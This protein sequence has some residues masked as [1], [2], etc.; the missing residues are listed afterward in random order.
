MLEVGCASNRTRGPRPRRSGAGPLLAARGG[1]GFTLIEVLVALAILVIGL[2]ATLTIFPR[3]FSAIEAGQQRT[4]AAQLAEGEIARWKLHPEALPDAIVATDYKGDLISA[5]LYNTHTSDNSNLE[6]LL[7]Y[8]ERVVFFPSNLDWVLLDADRVKRLFRPLVYDP[9]D[10]APTEFD[11][12]LAAGN[13]TPH[14]N[15]QP[16]TIYL[17]RTIIGERIDIRQLGTSELGVP[18]YLLSHAPLDVL[19][20][21]TDGNAYVDIYDARPWRYVPGRVA[22]DL[23]V[24]EFTATEAGTDLWLDFGPGDA[25]PAQPRAFKVDYT[26]YTGPGFARVLGLT[27]IVPANTTRASVSLSVSVDRETIQ[28]HERL[29]ALTDDQRDYLATRPQQWPRNAYYVAD[30]ET[31]VSGKIEFSPLLQ[32]DPRP[33]DITLVKVDYRVLDWQIL[34]FDVEVPPNG[35]VQLPVGQLKG[36]SYTNPPRQS[37][38]QE[39]ARG[40]KQYYNQLGTPS[41]LPASDPRTYAYLVAVDR[42]TGE[43]LVDHEGLTW[44]TNAWE[45]SKR[46]RVN[47]RDGLLYFNYALWQVER[48]DP[49]VDTPN[50]FGR[51]YRVFCRAQADWSVQLMI[52]ARQYPRSNDTLP[53]GAPAAGSAGTVLTYGWIPEEPR[54]IRFPL[55]DAGQAVAVDYYYWD[56][57]QARL[58][59]QQ[60]EVRNIGHPGVLLIGGEPYWVCKLEA[61]LA[62]QPNEW[63]PVVVRG[64]TL[65]ARS[66]WVTP[67]REATIQDLAAAFAEGR[68][69]RRSLEESWQHVIVTSYFSRTPI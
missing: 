6:R 13:V 68:A 64:L 67:G 56:E 23:D 4:V 39:V 1:R 30:P 46:F 27:I 43:I 17:P 36:A 40:V 53:G 5:T 49:Q 33:T 29:I 22:A 51:T 15:W 60:G 37:V 65:R 14:P 38:P 16:N 7:A 24:R 54:Q 20:R 12:A 28:V 41:Q 10:I 8:G 34:V 61:P 42:Q 19:R 21:E 2:Y 35:E 48:F 66:A 9:D 26:D 11:L 47:Y 45:R 50:R 32:S 44:P 18:F 62:E 52:A 3:G 59:Y 57:E 58:V 25:V 55:S 63:G 31:Q 69:A